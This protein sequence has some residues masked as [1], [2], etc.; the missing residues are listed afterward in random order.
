MM[1]LVE[2]RTRA[3]RRYVLLLLRK[4]ENNMCHVADILGLTRTHMYRLVRRLG[5]QRETRRWS[6]G[7]WDREPDEALP[8]VKG[9]CTRYEQTVRHA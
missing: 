4:H 7:V 9:N 5:I 8:A 3:E 2:F 1:T 6:K